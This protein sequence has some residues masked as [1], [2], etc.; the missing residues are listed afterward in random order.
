MLSGSDAM[1]IYFV[2]LCYAA[3]FI[4]G[5]ITLAAFVALICWCAIQFSKD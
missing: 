4:V 5:L 2:I 3:G 1:S